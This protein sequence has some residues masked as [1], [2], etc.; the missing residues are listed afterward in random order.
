MIL[1]NGT[2]TPAVF[3][4]YQAVSFDYRVF[5]LS[6]EIFATSGRFFFSL[7]HLPYFALRCE[8]SH[9]FVFCIF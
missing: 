3:T 9:A 4:M 7:V 8:I 6:E 5:A 2:D 1:H